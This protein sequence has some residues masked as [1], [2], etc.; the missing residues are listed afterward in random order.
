MGVRE[1][2]K[3]VEGGEEAVNPIEARVVGGR[4]DLVEDAGECWVGEA[5]EASGAKVVTPAAGRAG[6]EA[7]AGKGEGTTKSSDH[8]RF[9]FAL[10]VLL[11]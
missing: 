10:L 1:A 7:L 3:V 11:D 4:A 6:S 2:E 9:A 5:G 8:F